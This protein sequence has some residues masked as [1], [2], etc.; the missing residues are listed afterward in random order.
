M[1]FLLATSGVLTIG[2][3]FWILMLIWLVF[4]G[5]GYWRYPDNAKPYIGPSILLFA[6]F[7]LLG[8]GTFGFMIGG[9]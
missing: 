4:M 9:K 3:A 6:L 1:F 7:F 5:I 8:W 2:L